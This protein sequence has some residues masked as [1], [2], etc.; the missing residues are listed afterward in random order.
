MRELNITEVHAVSGG[1]MTGDNMIGLG[2][3][4]LAVSIPV[5]VGGAILGVPTLGIGFIGMAV[6]I[7]G[8]ALSGV[9]AIMGIIR[10]SRENGISNTP[11][12]PAPAA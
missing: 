10:S 6:G 3:L 4:G 8:T 1:A 12:D 7:V 11:V 9:M 2:S 5:I